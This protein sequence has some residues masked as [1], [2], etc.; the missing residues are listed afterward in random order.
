M[1][2][3]D[4]DAEIGRDVALVRRQ[5]ARAAGEA[6]GGEVRPIERGSG[7]CLARSTRAA[8]WALLKGMLF[9]RFGLQLRR[10]LRAFRHIRPRPIVFWARQRRCR[11]SRHRLRQCRSG[12]F[13]APFFPFPQA[14]TAE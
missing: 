10:R 11:C 14:R 13:T 2:V 7:F 6:P 4:H 8:S 9:L 1:I 3:G 12:L 5:R